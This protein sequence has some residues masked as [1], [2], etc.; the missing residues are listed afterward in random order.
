MSDRGENKSASVDRNLE[1]YNKV[2]KGQNLLKRNKDSVEYDFELNRSQCTHVPKINEPTAHL[3][4]PDRTL[5]EIKGLQQQ[6]Q[7]MEKG[8]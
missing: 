3:K 5:D 6:L 1:L 2:K 8:R 7:R 4:E